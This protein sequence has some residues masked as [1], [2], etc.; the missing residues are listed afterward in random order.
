M[1]KAASAKIAVLGAGLI[2][3]Y[4]GG[5]LAAGGADVTLIGRPRVLDD[6]RDNGL[7]LTD[8]TGVEASVPADRL[9]L[10]SDPAALAGADLILLT[11]KSIGTAAA[12][13]EIERFASPNAIIVS[14]QN[15]VSNADHLR[16]LLP[17]M[18]VVAGMVPYNVAQPGPGHY[19]KGTMG[20][21]HVEDV[22]AM[23]MHAPLFAA[24][25]VPLTLST[26]MAGVL[27][28]KLVVNLNNAANALSGLPLMQ[29]LAQRT[30]RRALALSQHEALGLLRQ[31]GIRP[32]KVFALPTW[33]LPY[34]MSLPD[35][36]YRWIMARGGTRIDRHAR[37][38]MAEDLAQGRRTEIDYLNGEF[39]ALAQR[40]GRRAPVNAR[41][42]ELVRAAEAGAPP[43]SAD[44]FYRALSAARISA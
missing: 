42:V 25:G 3:T 10:A 36:L 2:G 11:V 5:R 33:L 8:V 7:R 30:H 38:S 29:Q 9:K 27:W 15:G 35:G 26:D 20:D 22:P 12:A 17:D 6:L 18:T 24:A 1:D 4:V 41:V 16:R 32:A 28:G 40:L 43:L 13:A 44:A 19:H 14:L 31:A 34:V 21:L 39:V 37:S 23:R